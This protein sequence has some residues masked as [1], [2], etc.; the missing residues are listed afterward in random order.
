MPKKATRRQSTKP[1]TAQS[2]ELAQRPKSRTEI[3]ADS[4]A[5]LDDRVSAMR[6][7]MMANVERIQEAIGAVMDASRSVQVCCTTIRKNP[8]ILDCTP[9]SVMGGIA[10]A[11][12]YGWTI[13]GTLGHAYLLPFRNTKKNCMEAVLVPGYKGM[14]DLVQ[15]AGECTLSLESVHEGD[16]YDFQGRWELPIHN[17]SGHPDRRFRECTHAYVVARFKDGLIK[18][19][20]WTKGECLAHRDRY[21]SGW[22]R[23]PREDNPWHEEN[24]A[25]RTMCMKTV[26]LDACH[27]GEFPMRVEYAQLLNAESRVEGWEMPVGG[28]AALPEPGKAKAFLED[29]NTVAPADESAQLPSG[30]SP[31]N[32]DLALS[33]R[34]TLERIGACSDLE[35]IESI[36]LRWKESAGEFDEPADAI[37]SAAFEIE[38]AAKLRIVDLSG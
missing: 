8:Q 20:S 30:A 23:R 14:I 31:D 29:G 32:S 2:T 33:L 7:L 9:A 21:S 16:D 27:R 6:G 26:L 5:D 18:A 19:F 12:S 10:E 24:P 1:A 28:P 3:A 15:R 25:F 36:V 13:D 34:T 4:K 17:Y 22:K 35:H 11:G 38:T 37:E